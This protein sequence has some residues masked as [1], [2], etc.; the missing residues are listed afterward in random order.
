MKPFARVIAVAALALVA[1][2]SPGMDVPE[3]SAAAEEGVF[4][5]IAPFRSHGAVHDADNVE[6]MRPRIMGTH[7]VIS[8]GHYLATQAGYDVLRAGGNAFDAGVTAGMALKALKMDYAGWTGVAPL[9]IYSAAEDRVIT[10]V[11]AGTSPA[12]A[13]LDY[14]LEHGKSPI[15]NALIPA[16]VDVWLAALDRFGTL[17]FGEAAQPTL[18]I[19]E[20]GYHLYKMQKWMTEDQT[21]EILA[22]PYNR[23]F[24]FPNGVGEQRLG[25]LMVNADLGR[26]IR[27]M[28]EAEQQ[29]L[30]AGRSRSEGIRAARDAFYRGDPARDVDRF[31]REHDGIVRYEDMAGYESR[32]EEPLATGFNGYDVH[33]GDGWSQ[34]PRIIL[35]LNMLENYDLR[36]L[37]YNTPE[38]IHLV[39]Q[40]V[41]LAMADAHK[42]VGDPDFAPAPEGLYGKAYARERIGL[43]DENRAFPDMPPWG[44][45]V[46]MAAVAEGAPASFVVPEGQ[47]V[48]A[49]PEH[50]GSDDADAG[51]PSFDTSS[52]NVMDGEG[53][54]FSL[55]ESDGHTF[56]PMIPGWGF[57]LGNRMG[58]F[59]L[60]PDLANVMAPGKRPR[61][62][63]S[64]LLV[65]KDGEPFMGLST[66]GGDQQMQCLLQVFLNVVV[67][68]MSPEQALDQP[69]FGSYNFPATGS[70]VNRNP[71]VLYMEDRIPAETAEA[72]R[73]MG[74]DVR[75]WGLWNWRAG[76]PTVTWRDPE[77]GVMT[78]AGDVRRE[79]A[80]L[81]F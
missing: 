50:R 36:A 53:N 3:E 71:A 58:Q 29:A 15:N 67:W 61:N 14:F 69:R 16:D 18:R 12:L 6:A 49:A 35:M 47:P 45:P 39:S 43:I 48:A 40:V 38:Y 17:S 44:D 80:S 62:T 70:E 9:I 25:D 41:N 51:A 26:L 37:G 42:Y 2:C 10:R 76:A 20:E 65:V 22:F 11:G 75:S 31:F 30:A 66:P 34:G 74:H 21:E 8:S 23:D 68:G 4:A 19:A 81:G 28:M 55:T 54:V 63:N 52:L 32:W 79:T 13:T 60:D 5:T 77:T 73:A 78:A 56:T 59:N 1:A 64:P 57:G 24:W 72:L 27:Y 7:G 33:A 46:R